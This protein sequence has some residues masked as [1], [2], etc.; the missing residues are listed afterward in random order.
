MQTAVAPVLPS[1][2]GRGQRNTATPLAHEVAR[3]WH[4][5]RAMQRVATALVM[6]LAFAACADVP[7]DLDPDELEDEAGLAGGKEDSP[8]P[9]GWTDV[10][11]GV[12][13]QRVNAGDGVLIAYGG[14]TAQI[15]YSAAWASEL[16]DA[17]LG[18]EGVGHIYAVKGPRDAGYAAREIANT[19]L[20][21]HL[22][23]FDDGTARIYVVAHSSG[24]FVAHELL[25]QLRNT[26]RRDVLA[27]IGYANLDGG[28]SGLDGDIARSLANLA[29]VYAR[30]PSLSSGLSRNSGAA[31]SLASTYPTSQ[32]VE[33]RVPDTGCANGAGWCLHDVVIT[34][35]PHNKNTFDLARDY[36]DFAGRP[37][38]TEYLSAL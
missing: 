33:V 35:K 38:T 3:I 2:H 5:R 9:T 22:A 13:Y 34:H 18:A 29:F 25:S 31:R 24:S 6:A 37:V 20:R 32:L 11:L 16:V 27:R 30:D 8:M 7:D 26:G 28:G 21:A 14:Y 23:R 36:T 4:L 1:A 19:K 17:A 10:G 12:A 15:A